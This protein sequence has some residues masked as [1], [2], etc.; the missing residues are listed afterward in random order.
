[1]SELHPQLARDCVLLGHFPL[2]RLLLMNDSHF[3]WFILV[4]D[5]DE[6]REI[7]ELQAADRKQLLD[8]SCLLSEFLVETYAG[9]KLNVAALGNQVPQLHLHHIVRYA[10]DSA[11]P[12]P[13]WG[14]MPPKAYSTDAI[15][16]IK[17]L[18]AT[19]G[20]PDYVPATDA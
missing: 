14:K 5:R 10:T 15:L 17:T 20:L 12:A 13:I 9:D 18:F 7:Y 1:M 16:E 8:E 4:P 11:W 19:A 6:V 2:C 3:P